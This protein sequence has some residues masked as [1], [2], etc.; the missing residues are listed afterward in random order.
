MDISVIKVELK[1]LEKIHAM[2]IKS[3]TVLLKRYQGFIE[4]NSESKLKQKS[5]NFINEPFIDY[6]IIKSYGITIGVVRI[7]K[8]DSKPYCISPIFILA[9][10]FDKEITQEV[11]HS[12]GHI[13]YDIK[14]WKLDTILQE[15]ANCHLYEKFGYKKTGIAE[16]INSEMMLVHY[17]KH[18]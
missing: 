12:I 11:L 10:Y 17:E 9:E 15:Q 6:Y 14:D 3:F 4:A 5:F 18:I 7:V 8:N 1:D 16:I 2:R 13:Y